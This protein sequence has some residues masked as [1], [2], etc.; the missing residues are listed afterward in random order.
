M[1]IFDFFKKK[2]PKTFETNFSV[3]RAID[4]GELWIKEDEQKKIYYYVNGNIE[5][6]NLDEVAFFNGIEEQVKGLDTEI[7][8]RLVALLKEIEVPVL[9]TDW[10]ERYRMLSYQVFEL[11][12]D[13]E[14][15]EFSLRND[16]LDDDDG[17]IMEFIFEVKNGKIIHLEYNA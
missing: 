12:K 10:K 1:G 6:P 5:M 14:Y 7:N 3:F 16:N 11:D 9:F 4:K 2:K 15:W 8:A 17:I 13:N